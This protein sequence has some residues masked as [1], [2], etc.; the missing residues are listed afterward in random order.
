MKQWKSLLINF[1]LLL[2]WIVPWRACWSV[3]KQWEGVGPQ[4]YRLRPEE[5]SEH[6][7]IIP[8]F[9]FT[10]ESTKPREAVGFLQ[11]CSGSMAERELNLRPLE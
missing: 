7:N 9:Y 11:A 10:N 6:S 8:L 2:L 3:E 1:S 5:T 4:P